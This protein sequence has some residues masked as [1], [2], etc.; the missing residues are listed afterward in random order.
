MTIQVTVCIIYVILAMFFLRRLGTGLQKPPSAAGTILAVLLGGALVLRLVLGSTATGYETD[1]NTFKAWAGLAD[2]MGLQNLYY[3]DIFLDYPPGYIYVLWLL[4][5]VR[6]LMGLDASGA[7][8]TLLI[9]LPSIFADVL[10]GWLLYRLTEK[11][12]G[13]TGALFLA[14]LYLFCPAVLINSTVWG[15]ADSLCVL[16]LLAAMLLLRREGPLWVAAAGALYGVGLLMKPQMLLFAPVF[17]FFV[18]K[19]RDWKGLGLGLLTAFLMVFLLALPCTQNFDFTWLFQQYADTMGY[20]NYFTINAYNLYGLLG[21]NWFSMEEVPGWVSPVLTVVSA[22]LAVA[23]SGALY[24]KSKKKE[25]LFAVP[26]VIM[27]TIYLFAPKMHER[28]L[29]PALFFLLLCAGLT[30]DVRLYVSFL[31]FSAVHFLNVSFVLYLNNSYIEPNSPVILCL[32]AMHLLLYGYLLYVL[33]R[34]FWK[35]EVLTWAPWQANATG[36]ARELSSMPEASSG[37]RRMTSRDWILAG[38]VTAAYAVL[39][40]WCLGSNTMPVTT[41]A[42]EVGESVTV[43]LSEE[44]GVL[45]YLPGLTVPVKGQAAHT[46]VDVRVEVSSDGS[47]WVEAGSLTDDSVFAW[48]EFSL[49]EGSYY[50]R[51]TASSGTP[52]LNEI[53]V[54]SLD[55]QSLLSLT[56]VDGEGQA[57]LD[58]QAEVPLHPTWYDSTYFDEIY[59]ARTAYEHLLGAEPY[60][61]TH[62]TLG[63]LIMSI[64]VVLFGMNPFGWRF[65]GALLGVLMLPI[66]YHFIKRLFGKTWLALAGTLLFALDFMHFTQTRIATIDTYAVF[67]LLLM[68]DTMLCFC[69]QDL[70]GAPMK[71]LLLPLLLC[72]VFTGLGIASK[73]TAAYAAVGLAVLFFWR[74]FQA[75]RTCPDGEKIALR[76]RTFRLILWC[77]LFFLLIP[78]GIYYAAFLPVLLLPGHDASLAGWWGY[79]IHMYNYHSGLQAEHSFSSSWYQWPVMSRPVWYHI[80]YHYE[81]VPNQVCTISGFGNPILWWG[82][83]P[84]LFFSVYQWLKNRSRKAGFIMVGFLA[85]YLPWVLVSR[86]TFLYHYF[87]ALPFALLALLLLFHCW[88]ESG[89]YTRKFAVGKW[90]ITVPQVSMMG[91]LVLAGIL[92]AV[93]FPVISGAATTADYAHSLQWLPGWFFCG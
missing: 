32:S 41:W 1:I 11:K 39:G 55:G 16:L 63:K 68:Y 46:G 82:S 93:F 49:P 35:E 61:N 6:Q 87:T 65:M 26:C 18:L 28:Y 40:F 90:A 60:E 29:F 91:V 67:F 88:E 27:A 8:F 53:A 33:Y 31:L 15:Q 79:Q 64:G 24:W 57:L 13:E 69:Q 86:L 37:E 25:A 48:Q 76:Q 22:L 78:F 45:R 19:R 21:L 30:R 34:V 66:L 47:Q 3:S 51:L 84:A 73:W 14:G 80:T 44:G 4:E 62:P 17:L 10:C 74:L 75:W 85:A 12:A 50:L 70:R 89:R 72:G 56:L 52:V 71:K 7:G 92:L 42:P 9:K 23:L 38:I 77:C 20:Y 58:E 54:T 43:S 81:G 83:I 36:P 59:H 5:K 2:S